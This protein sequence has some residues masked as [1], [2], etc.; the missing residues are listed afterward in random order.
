MAVD[1][2]CKNQIIRVIKSKLNAYGPFMRPGVK[3]MAENKLNAFIN[4]IPQTEF[5]LT[6]SN[7]LTRHPEVRTQN[8]DAI[9]SLPQCTY[10]YTMQ[11]LIECL[12]EIK[13]YI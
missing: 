2:D 3:V 5:N 4:S 13:G 1:N 11:E 7:Y 10:N 6:L 9:S 12:H 8:S